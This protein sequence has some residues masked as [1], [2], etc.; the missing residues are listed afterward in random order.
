MELQKGDT[1][2]RIKEVL[3]RP[4]GVILLKNKQILFFD[5]GE[6]TLV[7]GIATHLDIL[8]EEEALAEQEKKEQRRER[9]ARLVEE[10]IRNRVAEG[11]SIKEDKL[12][13]ADFLASSAYTRLEFWRNFRRMYPEVEISDQLT[14]TIKERSQEL[15]Q[16]ADEQRVAQL[17]ARVQVAENRARRAERRSYS[18]YHSFYNY[19]RPSFGY[20]YP[21]RVHYGFAG[22]PKNYHHGHRAR[23]SATYQRVNHINDSNISTHS[24]SLIVS[25]GFYHGNHFQPQPAPPPVRF[26]TFF[27][28]EL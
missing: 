21:A 7:D 10:R 16:Q 1:A 11:L 15:E 5:R 26:P 9:A 28:P 19:A 23:S 3:G 14:A 8:N 2:E 4:N 6:V 17:E 13:N 12:T 25:S 18:R 24:V 27:A 22:H 20:R